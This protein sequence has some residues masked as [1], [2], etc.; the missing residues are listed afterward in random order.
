MLQ[1]ERPT[2]ALIAAAAE[3]CATKDIDPTADI[4]ASVA[5]RR[6][7]ANVLTRRAL[8]EAFQRAGQEPL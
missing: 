6:H 7:L 2:P 4:H 5:F 8:T 3:T 1:G